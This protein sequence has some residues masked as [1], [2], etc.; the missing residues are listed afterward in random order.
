MDTPATPFA[1]EVIQLKAEIKTL[2]KE[3]A[4]MNAAMRA[5]V[6]MAEITERACVATIKS[7]KS[8]CTCKK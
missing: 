8:K 2:K 1:D 7:I 4:A 6:A 5:S 3:N